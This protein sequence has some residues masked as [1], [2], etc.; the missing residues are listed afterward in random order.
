MVD[1]EKLLHHVLSDFVDSGSQDEYYMHIQRVLKHH[2]REVSEIQLVKSDGERLMARMES[3]IA[4]DDPVQ[5][6]VILSDVTE[7]RRLENKQQETVVRSMLQRRLI[8]QSEMERVE[9]ARN[10]HDGPIQRLSGL[11]F[12]IQIIKEILKENGVDDNNAYIQQMGEEVSDLIVE[13]RGICNNLRPPILKRFGLSK[14]ISEN[15][16]DFQ[17]KYPHTKIYLE[18]SNDLSDL[19]DPITLSLYRI[20]QQAM[21]NIYN[22]ANASKV[23]IRLKPETQRVLF[24]IQDNGRGLSVPVD[25]NENARQGHF[26]LLGMKERT[27]AFGGIL[28]IISNNGEGTTIQVSIPLLANDQQ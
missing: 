15:I 9:L 10:L 11:G 17:E 3:K 26:G 4:Q 23:W 18:M 14:A 8:E 28:Q 7:Q 5:L 20:Y 21:H 2:H 12:S 22:H 6:M 19:P 13:L 27:D 16:I 1:Q 24:E 25:W